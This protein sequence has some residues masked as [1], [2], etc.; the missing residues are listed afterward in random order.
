MVA[1]LLLVAGAGGH[2]AFAAYVAREPVAVVADVVEVEAEEDVLAQMIRAAKA[3]D[4]FA[5]WALYWPARERGA[6][7]VTHFATLSRSE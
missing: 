4:P 5:V 3:D 6:V 1:A 7:D 2:A